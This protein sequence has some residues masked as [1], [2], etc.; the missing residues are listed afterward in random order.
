MCQLGVESQSLSDAAW[1]CRGY[2]VDRPGRWTCRRETQKGQSLTRLE[3]LRG[4][5]C[6]CKATEGECVGVRIRSERMLAQSDV[7]NGEQP[8][9]HARPGGSGA[10]GPDVES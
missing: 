7:L 4:W 2:H 5:A 10:E 9:G 8:S 6:C 1:P 3:G